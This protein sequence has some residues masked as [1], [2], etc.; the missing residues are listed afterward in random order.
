MCASSCLGYRLPPTSA[1]AGC[2][3]GCRVKR[4]ESERHDQTQRTSLFMPLT[5][6]AWSLYLALQN[7]GSV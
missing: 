2:R 7:A 1:F 5:S 3:I 6:T 4:D